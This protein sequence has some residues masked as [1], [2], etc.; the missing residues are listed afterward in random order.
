[1]GREVEGTKK[2]S[3]KQE[4]E[5]YLDPVFMILFW[6]REAI[7]SQRCAFYLEVHIS[8]CDDLIFLICEVW[9][10]R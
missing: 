9:V 2:L 5:R 3:G 1:M 6:G 10:C 7:F 4:A 8:T